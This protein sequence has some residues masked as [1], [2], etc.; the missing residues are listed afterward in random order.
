MQLITGKTKHH[1]TLSGVLFVERFKAC[2]L[3]GETTLA[4]GI[5]HQNHLP[6]GSFRHAGWW[7]SVDER[8]SS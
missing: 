1:Q 5:H 7:P 4:G 6:W 2:V 3:W 8:E